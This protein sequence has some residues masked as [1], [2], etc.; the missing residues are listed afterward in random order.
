MEREEEEQERAEAGTRLVGRWQTRAAY[1]VLWQLMAL[2]GP[3]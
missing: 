1:T 2:C 3:R